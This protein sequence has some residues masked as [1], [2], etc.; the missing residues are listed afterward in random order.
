MAAE[1][2]RVRL[3]EAPLPG[4]QQAFPTNASRPA[5]SPNI[6]GG[7][8]VPPGKYPWVA[9]LGWV[10]AA[11]QVRPSGHADFAGADPALQPV[12]AVANVHRSTDLTDFDSYCRS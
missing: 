6:V 8:L 5:L 10:D 11:S 2:G 3:G 12:E 7:A 1:S 4:E 9:L